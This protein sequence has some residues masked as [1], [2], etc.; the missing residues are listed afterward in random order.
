MSLAK[1]DIHQCFKLEQ[2]SSTDPL[3]SQKEALAD[4]S[5]E[6]SS[7]LIAGHSREA[8]VDASATS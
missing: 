3:W 8:I 5:K 7:S 6:L 1:R 4:G 2:Q